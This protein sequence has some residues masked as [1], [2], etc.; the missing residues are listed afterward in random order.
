MLAA[1][2]LGPTAQAQTRTKFIYYF[3]PSSNVAPVFLAK[4]RGYFDELGLDV[5]LMQTPSGVRTIELLHLGQI[6]AGNVAGIPFI[7]GVAKG[8]K[9]A[10]IQDNGGYDSRNPQQTLLVK[11]KSSIKSLPDLSGKRVAVNA[12]GAHGHVVMLAE[13]LPFAKLKRDDVRFVE[14]GWPQM[15]PS[16]VSGAIDVGLVWE[17]F[18]TMAPPDIG[19]L[20]TLSETMPKGV[21]PEAGYAAALILVNAEYAQKNPKVIA[22][23]HQGYLRGLKQFREN[24]EEAHAV[25]S[26]YL[27]VPVDVLRKAPLNHYTADGLPPRAII[28]RTADQLRGL[29]LLDKPI[30]MGRHILQP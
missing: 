18:V 21:Y 7:N 14:M 19:K 13:V 12:F 11:D 17:P 26:K 2:A 29:G 8:L 5:E 4:D 3:T 23:W 30:D 24:V 25:T 9:V 20:S 10:A 6:Q 1:L 28:Q 15:I 16:L 22:A 27:K